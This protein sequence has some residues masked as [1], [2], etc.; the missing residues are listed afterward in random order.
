M[1]THEELKAY[2]RDHKEA[3]EVNVMEKITDTKQYEMDMSEI[4]AAANN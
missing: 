2:A 3:G 1:L 4:K